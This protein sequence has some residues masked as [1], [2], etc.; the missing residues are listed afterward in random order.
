M[1]SIH[2]IHDTHFRESLSH[3]DLAQDFLDNYLPPAVRRHVDLSTL[4]LCKDSF[5]SADKSTF[6]SDLLYKVAT[7]AKSE[8]FIYL[9]F[10]H[11]SSPDRFTALQMLRYMVEI[12]EQYLD[13]YP[14]PNSL[15]CIIPIV[16]YHG[17]SSQQGITMGELVDI[18]GQDMQTYVPDFTLDFLDFSPKTDRKIKGQIITQLFVL[19]LQ[20]KNEPKA[21][22]R[23]VEIFALIARLD[24][25]ATSME[26]IR[27]IFIYLNQVMDIDKDVVTKLTRLH[28]TA[29]K[30][31]TVMTIA[32]QWR[33]EGRMEGEASG[34]AKAL[35]RLL[36]RKF[37]EHVF[38]LSAQDRLVRATPEQL[39]IWTD[40]ILDAKTIEDVFSV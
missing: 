13:Q 7:T 24:D 18:P 16:V 1:T 37:G 29:N 15:P 2:H 5:V 8:A 36:S 22:H 20:A 11:K 31:D 38:K 6:Y 33:K 26:W 40:R 23:L 3:K 32:E 28:L 4:R 9:L 17:P 34:Q 39:D 14:N 27:S 35:S 12:W 21:V 10:E 30:E 19:C 25:S